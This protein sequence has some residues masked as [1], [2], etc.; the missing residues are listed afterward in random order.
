LQPLWSAP[1]P[2]HFRYPGRKP[3]DYRKILTDILFVLKTGIAWDD[4]PAFVN[5]GKGGRPHQSP[6]EQ[7][8]ECRAPGKPAR[9]QRLSARVGPIDLRTGRIILEM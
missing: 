7:N 2:R 1:K 9:R 3:L 6:V 8:H 5:G 4:L